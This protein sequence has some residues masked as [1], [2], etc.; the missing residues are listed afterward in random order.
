MHAAVTSAAAGSAHYYEYVGV[1]VGYRVCR[2]DS[3]FFAMLET[4]HTCYDM[5][6]CLG[7]SGA[8]SAITPSGCAV[9]SVSWL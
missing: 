9:G 2:F 3:A 5:R 6:G 1:A 4:D 8:D 7:G